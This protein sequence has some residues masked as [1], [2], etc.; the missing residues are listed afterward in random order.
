MY[1]ILLVEDDRKIRE[2]IT[3]Y[4]EDI[5]GGAMNI[6]VAPDGNTA[7]V[8]AYD[9][10]YDLLILDVMLP[11]ID[12]FSVCKEV[13][14]TNDVPIIFITAKG[15]QEDIFRGYALGCDDYIVKPFSIPVFYKKAEALIKR[16]KGLVKGDVLICGNIKLNPNNGIV[17]ASENTVN[18]TAKEYSI[19]KILLENKGKI[20]SRQMLID[21]VW[22]Y[23]NEK[24]ERS[25]DPHIKNLRK[26]LGKEANHIKTIIGRGFIAGD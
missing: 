15:T 5:S 22:G 20:V 23:N 25:L 16:S 12:G 10:I 3:D 6:D 11:E 17:T 26:S 19:L 8:K 14:K 9:N 4:F 24:D 18:L 21:S 1:N 7:L 13:R 2:V